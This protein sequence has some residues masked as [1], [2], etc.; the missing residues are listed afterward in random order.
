MEFYNQKFRI[1]RWH[2]SRSFKYSRVEIG[3]EKKYFESP[4]NA[5][6]VFVL[7]FLILAIIF[8]LTSYKDFII[9]VAVFALL[10]GLYKIFLAFT[11]PIIALNS[12]GI[13]LRAINIPW[14]NIRSIDY[15]W[16]SRVLF[17][18]IKLK[19]DKMVKE[20]VSNLSF[21]KDFIYLEAIIRA[22]RKKYRKAFIHRKML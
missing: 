7:T 16:K 13:E 14:K 5:L 19:N 12:T 2:E 3:N 18:S 1:Q 10:F 20:K 15:I 21:Q 11:I 17:L 4:L 9:R 6:I 22:F 8:Y